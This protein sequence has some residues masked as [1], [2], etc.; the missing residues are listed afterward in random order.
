MGQAY[1]TSGYHLHLA[2]EIV[3][4]IDSHAEAL[5]DLADQAEGPVAQ[6]TENTCCALA[7]TLPC[8]TRS[9]AKSQEKAEALAVKSLLEDDQP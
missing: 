8:C 2:V 1:D 9:N 5:G 4:E 7:R 6:D 3:S